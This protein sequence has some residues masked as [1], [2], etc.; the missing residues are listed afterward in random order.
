MQLLI[1][2]NGEGFINK[3]IV[4]ASDADPNTDGDNPEVVNKKLDLEN[5]GIGLH[6]RRLAAESWEKETRGVEEREVPGS[7][8]S[9]RSEVTGSNPAT[10]TERDVKY[11]FP[12]GEYADDV[13]LFVE[14]IRASGYV[15]ERDRSGFSIDY[16]VPNGGFR[17]TV[18]WIAPPGEAT[19][20]GARDITLGV[21]HHRREVPKVV[22]E[23]IEKFLVA[24]TGFM[25]EFAR[26]G[27]DAMGVHL[28]PPRFMECQFDAEALLSG[29]SHELKEIA[30]TGRWDG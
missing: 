17:V 29:L 30:E 28:P 19:G 14:N 2:F 16:P 27:R 22:T 23:H 13:G 24:Y 11:I 5:G 15:L 18:G 21:W 8:D 26:I 6:H 20:P 7:V 4:L 9:K 25:G 10:I 1:D 12:R 3:I